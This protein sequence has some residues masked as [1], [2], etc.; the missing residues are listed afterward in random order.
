MDI[1]VVD[2]LEK[3]AV[4]IDA[5][6][7][8]DSNIKKKEHEKLEKYQELK[9]EVDCRLLLQTSVKEWVALRSSVNSSVVQRGPVV[10]FPR[11]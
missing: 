2:K 8:S 9:K 10:K 7:V 1:V 4:V 3:M 6:I 5:T 11:Y